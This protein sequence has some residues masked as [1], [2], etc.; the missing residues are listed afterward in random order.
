MSVERPGLSSVATYNSVSQDTQNQHPLPRVSYGD[1]EEGPDDEL[2]DSEGVAPAKQPPTTNSI[3]RIHFMLGAALLLPWNSMITATSYFQSRL[4]TVPAYRDNFSFVLSTALTT[5]NVVFLLHATLTAKTSPLTRRL[6]SSA[7]FITA[8]FVFFSVTALVALPPIPFFYLVIGA[9]ILQSGAV[10]YMNAAVFALASLFGPL[11]MQAAMAGQAAAGVL[12]S[13]V[14]MITLYSSLRSSSRDSEK[15]TSGPA[16]FWFFTASTLFMLATIGVHGYVARQGAYRRVVE[17][18]ETAQ[19]APLAHGV[20]KEGLAYTARVARN[21]LIF[22]FTVASVF[23]VTLSVFPAI[24]ASV[25][26]SHPAPDGSAS[27]S[28]PFMFT[29]FHFLIFNIG[30]WLGRYLCSF[31]SFVIHDPRILLS[32]SLTRVLFVPLFLACNFSPLG[33]TSGSNL[34]VIFFVLVLAL[35]TS[36]G[37]LGSLCMMSAADPAHNHRVTSEDVESAATIASF[38]LVGGLS[39]GSVVSIAVGTLVPR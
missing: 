25:R 20:D 3:R 16:A 33:N 30:D 13:L 10:S 31:P 29:A 4:A 22:N 5:C 8:L 7:L 34:D 14:Q 27:L 9:G 37:W 32:L 6:R 35:G 28:H 39:L 1:E 21:N 12:V 38:C 19:S 17:P 2:D 36:N 23:I 24:T 15:D 18:V 11:T 26:P